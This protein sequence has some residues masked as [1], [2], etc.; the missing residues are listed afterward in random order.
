MLLL[1]ESG[2]GELRTSERRH[3]STASKQPDTSMRVDTSIF[4]HKSSEEPL[5]SGLDA[6]ASRQDR[7]TRPTNKYFIV[8]ERC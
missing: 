3:L 5:V 1:A 4:D 2:V 6:A 7:D 8:N